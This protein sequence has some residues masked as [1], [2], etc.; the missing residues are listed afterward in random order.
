MN[1]PVNPERATGCGVALL[2][3]LVA[4]LFVV[5][6]G[7][8]VFVIFARVQTSK[9]IDVSFGRL[10]GPATAPVLPAA[11]A[12][13]ALQPFPSPQDTMPAEP[14]TSPGAEAIAV[15][16]WLADLKPLEV[17]G[18]DLRGGDLQG[19]VT[20]GGRDRRHGLRVRPIAGQ[21]ECRISYEL[22]SRPTELR[23]VAGL[24]AAA[25]GPAAE[26]P[27]TPSVV[28][29]IYGDGNLLWESEPLQEPGTAAPLDVKLS[30]VTVL[31][32]VVE[33]SDLAAAPVCAWGDLELVT[34]TR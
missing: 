2:L 30:G 19:S 26:Q 16:A 1:R 13:S 29:R 11:P 10:G 24:P 17:V 7:V 20:L 4:V 14:D 8:A 31:A 21:G 5:L 34:A 3:A 33:C 6:A 22:A 28:F 12:P 23:G 18:V 15:G 25:G 32:L 27:R 9:S